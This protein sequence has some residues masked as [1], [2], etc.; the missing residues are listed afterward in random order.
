MNMEK[1]RGLKNFLK[2]HQHIALH[3]CAQVRQLLKSYCGDDS[4]GKFY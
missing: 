1:E 3:W 4:A 2:L